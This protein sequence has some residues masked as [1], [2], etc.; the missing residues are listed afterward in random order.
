[1]KTC[2]CPCGCK[3]SATTPGELESVFGWRGKLIQSYCKA[4]R[5]RDHNEI[6]STTNVNPIL[7]LIIWNKKNDDYKNFLSEIPRFDENGKF[8]TSEERR[9]LLQKHLVNKHQKLVDDFSELL[10]KEDPTISEDMIIELFKVYN[11]DITMPDQNS[12]YNFSISGRLGKNEIQE[13]WKS[14]QNIAVIITR[15][16]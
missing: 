13:E 9:N 8:I 10:V 6:I 5:G 15:I 2:P 12:F 3:A 14:K 11:F 1:M 16:N 4:C 7:D